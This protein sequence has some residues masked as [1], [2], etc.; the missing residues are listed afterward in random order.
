MRKIFLYIQFKKNEKSNC[1]NLTRKYFKPFLFK[2][3]EN[4]KI[5]Y[6]DYQTLFHNFEEYSKPFKNMLKI[7][8]KINLLLHI[9]TLTKIIFFA[10]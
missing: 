4:V 7:L 6:K 9:M 3:L 2:N 8:M 5:R 1:L 10:Q